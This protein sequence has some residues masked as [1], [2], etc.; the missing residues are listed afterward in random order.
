VDGAG[1]RLLRFPRP[2]GVDPAEELSNVR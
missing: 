1:A 2:G